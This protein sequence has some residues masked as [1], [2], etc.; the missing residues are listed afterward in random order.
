MIPYLL[1]LALYSMAF[2]AASEAGDRATKW[3][4]RILTLGLFV[5]SLGGMVFMTI[6]LIRLALA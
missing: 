5:Y 4:Q 1:S 2:A 3:W 6:R